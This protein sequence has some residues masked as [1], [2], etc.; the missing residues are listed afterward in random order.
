MDEELTER[1]RLFLERKKKKDAATTASRMK[2]NAW[3]REQ[4][5]RALNKLPNEYRNKISKH[6]EPPESHVGIYWSD[7]TDKLD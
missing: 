7:G 1:E 5:E 4:N 3:L 2:E 6:R